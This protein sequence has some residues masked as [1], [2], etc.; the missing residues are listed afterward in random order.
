MQPTLTDLRKRRG[1]TYRAL[2][3]EAGIP[4]TAV[5]EAENSGRVPNLRYARAICRALQVGV[6]SVTWGYERESR[7]IG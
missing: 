2:A 7:R 5:Y 3:A 1:L 6:D 4:L